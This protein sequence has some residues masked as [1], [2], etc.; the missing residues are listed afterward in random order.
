M[1]IKT[2]IKQNS[3]RNNNKLKFPNSNIDVVQTY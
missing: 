2:L 1:Q 3:I